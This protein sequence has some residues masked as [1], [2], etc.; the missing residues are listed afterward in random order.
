MRIVALMVAT[1]LVTIASIAATSGKWFHNSLD[2]DGYTVTSDIGF[3][4][5]TTCSAITGCQSASYDCKGDAGDK[6]C[7][8]INT[9]R[10]LMVT[11]DILGFVGIAALGLLFVNRQQAVIIRYAAMGIVGVIA[12]FQFITM[13]V[14]ASLKTDLGTRTSLGVGFGLSIVTWLLAAATTAAM[15]FIFRQIDADD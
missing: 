11:A 12:F 2:V 10:G 8:R 7:G 14:G 9:G 6:T 15:P 13:C 5:V 3:F 1:L 4:T